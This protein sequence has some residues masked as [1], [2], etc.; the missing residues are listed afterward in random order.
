[1]QTAHQQG[2]LVL[3]QNLDPAYTSAEVEVIVLYFKGLF[4]FYI[5]VLAARLHSVLCQMNTYNGWYLF[6]FFF[7][8]TLPVQLSS[9]MYF[10]ENIF[11]PSQQSSVL[12]FRILSG[13]ALRNLVQQGWYNARQ[14]LAHI[15]VWGKKRKD[16][17]LQ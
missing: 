6:S 3:L 4:F 5:F 10:F 9:C 16:Q 15:L 14:F 1:M 12:C 13:M 11:Q 2:I 8:S 17:S 7:V